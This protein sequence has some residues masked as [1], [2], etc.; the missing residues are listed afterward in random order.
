MSAAAIWGV[1]ILGE[2]PDYVT[3]L[4]RWKGGGRSEPGVRRTAAGQRTAHIEEIDGFAVTNLAR[5]AIDVAFATPFTQAVG[6]VDWCIYRKNSKATGKDALLHELRTFEGRRGIKLA[7]SVV[8]FAS[9]LSD[10]FGES[11]CRA[12]IHL[13]GFAA[14]QLQVEFHDAEG[15][16]VVDFYWPS[17]RVAAEFDGKQKYTVAEYTGDHPEEVVWREKKRQDRLLRQIEGVERLITADV[18]NPA[19]LVAILSEAG[20]PRGGR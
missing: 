12:V 2:F 11:Q 15:K 14:P 7:R 18:S 17:V 3:I 8:A 16:M 13:M 19:R 10:S 5:T 9:P 4:D 1:P 6:S 20:V